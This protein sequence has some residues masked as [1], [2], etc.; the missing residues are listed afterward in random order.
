MQPL[1]KL[2]WYNFCFKEVVPGGVIRSFQ[3]L[4]SVLNS[5]QKQGTVIFV[6]LFGASERFIRNLLCHF[7]SLNIQNYVL[8]GPNSDFLLDLARRG[9]PVIDVD[10]FL[11][12]TRAH[13]MKSLQGSD[14]EVKRD[15]LAKGYVIQKSVESGYNSWVVDGNMLFLSSGPYF[16]TM[17]ANYDF[18]AGKS[19]EILFVRSSSSAQKIWVDDFIHKLAAMVDSAM[20]G[21]LTPKTESKKFVYAV[22]ELLKQKGMTIKWVDEEGNSSLRIDSRNGNQTSVGAR[23]KM[24]FWS[25]EI[26]SDTIQKR[27]E[28]LGLWI[29][30]SEDSCTAVVCH[31][32]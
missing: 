19:P 3:E 14:M 8:M 26:G 31:Q 2:K 11:S 27:L 6:S 17:N 22:R 15:I 16:D 23:K 12:S 13:E 29:I 10:Q 20:G 28:E 4:G 21:G 32:S 5:V 9:H 30:D 1:T 24:V 18:H 7:E 25:P